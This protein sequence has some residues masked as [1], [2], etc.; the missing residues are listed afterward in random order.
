MKI[1]R[2]D[3][4]ISGA[5][6]PT[7]DKLINTSVSWWGWWCLVFFLPVRSVNGLTGARSSKS[8]TSL[9]EWQRRWT[10]SSVAVDTSVLLFIASVDERE[11]DKWRPSTSIYK[12]VSWLVAV[13]SQLV[14]LRSSL[15]CE[16]S[17]QL[18]SSSEA[19]PLR[20]VSWKFEGRS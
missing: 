5:I 12:R 14:S 20:T 13:S 9:S 19:K 18:L 4:L 7:V 10:R 15:N 3:S 2:E 6:R 16:G 17:K 11:K 1:K 8:I